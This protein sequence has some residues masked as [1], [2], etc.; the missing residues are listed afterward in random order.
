MG[1][2]VPH[3][4][5]IPAVL[6]ANKCSSMALSVILVIV[7]SPAQ[8]SC[9][10]RDAWCLDVTRYQDARLS[11]ILIRNPSEGPRLGAVN[12]TLLTPNQGF[13]GSWCK[14]S[15]RLYLRTVLRSTGGRA[16]RVRKCTRIRDAWVRGATPPRKLAFDRPFAW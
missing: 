3:N 14:T 6:W 13:L 7:A 9:S 5:S 15:W 10:F 4:A 2:M 1:F 16:A 11:W 8:L 12:S